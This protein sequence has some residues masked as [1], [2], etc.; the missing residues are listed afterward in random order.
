MHNGLV[1]YVSFLCHSFILGCIP[2]CGGID[3]VGFWLFDDYFLFDWHLYILEAW[4]C[5]QLWI[6]WCVG[7]RKLEAVFFSCWVKSLMWLSRVAL[8]RKSLVQNY[9][10]RK[11]ISSGLSWRA[12]VGGLRKWD[13]KS[14]NVKYIIHTLPPLAALTPPENCTQSLTPSNSPSIVQNI[15]CIP[16]SYP[17]IHSTYS[18]SPPPSTHR[19]FVFNAHHIHSNPLNCELTL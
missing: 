11:Q 1:G 8:L 6:L 3:L 12:E 2:C 10:K 14:K 15:F 16:K 18:G 5:I 19:L 9:R 7:S 13:G 4:R 17:R